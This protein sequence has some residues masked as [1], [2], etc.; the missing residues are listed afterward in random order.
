MKGKPKIA[1][2]KK[3]AALY[4][5]IREILESARTRVARSVN[6]T[7]VVANW[8]VGR[9]I[10]EEEQRGSRKAEYGQRLIVELSEKLQKDFGAGYSATNLKLFR[11]FFFCYPKLISKGISHAVC[12]QSP[13]SEK[14][15]IPV[16]ISVKNQ[17]G[18]TPCDQSWEPGQL[19]V[20]LSWS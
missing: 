11:Q 20:N 12:D 5:R 19:H 13:L 6:S 8:L 4:D 14:N 7:Q 1:P 10:V 9:E 2:V 18:H 17:I 16:A 15:N 3:K